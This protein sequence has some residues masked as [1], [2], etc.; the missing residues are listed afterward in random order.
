MGRD[1]SRELPL[2]FGVFAVS[3]SCHGLPVHFPHLTCSPAGGWTDGPYVSGD[4][5]FRRRVVNCWGR[6]LLSERASE[7]LLLER[8]RLWRSGRVVGRLLWTLVS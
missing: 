8:W 1:C 6:G 2:Q 4:Y 3:H 5:R 7:G